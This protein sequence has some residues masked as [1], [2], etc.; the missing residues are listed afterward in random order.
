MTKSKLDI[1]AAIAGRLRNAFRINGQST[2]GTQD[3]YINK[4]ALTEDDNYSPITLQSINPLMTTGHVSFRT[5]GI[6]IDSTRFADLT[7]WLSCTCTFGP[8]TA[9]LT[10]VVESTGEVYVYVSSNGGSGWTM[11]SKVHVNHDDTGILPA[12]RIPNLPAS[13]ITSGVFN[14]DRIPELPINKIIGTGNLVSSQLI[15]ST[16]PPDNLIGQDGDLWGVL[17]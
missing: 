14:I 9:T 11:K 3:V 4:L 2:D 12:N 10:A 8:E 13:R 5:Q 1:F 7:I 17:E 16:A 15:V 6:K